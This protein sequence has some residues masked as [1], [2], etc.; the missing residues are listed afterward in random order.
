MKT[1][2]RR[3][4]FQLFA[5]LFLIVVVGL[6]W[7]AESNT[8]HQLRRILLIFVGIFVIGG[9]AKMVGDIFFY[10]FEERKFKKNPKEF[11]EENSDE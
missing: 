3:R 9:L 11:F 4:L 7:F 8:P 10:V 2:N 1:K 5:F 6:I